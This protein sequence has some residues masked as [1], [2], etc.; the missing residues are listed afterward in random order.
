LDADKVKDDDVRNALE[1]VGLGHLKDRLD[2]DEPWEQ[3][4]S[5]GEKQRLAFARLLIHR[6]DLI[7]MD[8]ATSALDPDSQERL[9][10][11]ID[12]KMPN[13]T[14]ISVGHRPELEAFHERKLVLEHHP[15]GARLI[16][17]E[18]ITF[19]PGPGVALIRRLW[20]WRRGANAEDDARTDPKLEVTIVPARAAA[21]T[22]ESA[23]RGP[24][25]PFAGAEPKSKTSKAV[26]EG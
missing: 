10:K 20:N 21:A 4:L 19:L 9:L 16:H 1:E 8:E 18:Y 17:D 26:A 13:A 22:P 7:V 6:P 2:D 15:G 12:E 23:D 5:G 14:L 24:P 11:L 3:T 25:E